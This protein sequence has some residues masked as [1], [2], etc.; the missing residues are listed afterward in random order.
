ME[1]LAQS[2][3]VLWGWRRL[4]VAAAAGALSV[5]ALP[6]FG[7]PPILFVTLPVL[8]WL[9]DGATATSGRFRAALSAAAIGWA[10]GFGYF[11][12]GLYWI[13]A[14]FLV[15]AED[16]LWALPIAISALPIGLGLF[17]GAA[18]FLARLVWRPGPWRVVP[19]ATFM[20]ASELVR[21]EILT[22]FPW[23]SFGYA[24]AVTPVSMQA[25]ALSTVYGLSFAT[26]LIFAAPAA[27][28]PRV[29]G[30]WGPPVVAAGLVAAIVGYGVLRLGSAT[31]D[32]S[33]VF[34]RIVQPA[35][36]Q[37]E[38]WKPE[39]RS[40]IF[41]TLMALSDQATSP[42]IM[43]TADLDIIIWPESALTF[44]YDREPGAQAAVAATLTSGTVLI[45]GLQRHIADSTDPRGFRAYNS[46]AAIDE[47]GQVIASYD[48]V[49]L[50][51]FGEFLPFQ[52]ALEA[53]GVEQLTRLPGGFDAG[54]SREPVRLD[55]LPAFLPLICYEIIFPGEIHTGDD[56]ADWLLNVTNDAWYGESPGPYQH[57][58]Q[59]R[60]RAVEEGLPVVRA[61]NT[62][63]SVIYD[64]YGRE[65]ASAPLNAR[66][67]VD[68][69][70]P[71][72]VA[73]PPIAATHGRLPAVLLCA[74]GFLA[75][76]VRY[77]RKDTFWL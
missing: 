57:L 18:L 4:A 47:D 70:L 8:V 7:L 58:L 36:Q 1:R 9:V 54:A 77:A 33:G 32:G 50:V 17:Y 13:G 59:A 39:N 76:L 62:G 71:A 44:L 46:I 55:G 35:I 25:A 68:G 19:F 66:G 63:I 60:L 45:T 23:N 72:P 12:A 14:A 29:C 5:I 38:K 34:V 48:K 53:W 16:F 37:E 21:G 49:N 3:I 10:F 40:S 67:V 52:D 56:R 31:P 6:P 41:N 69:E 20:T 42:E 15:E 30:S 28:A 61:A 51:P 65:I 26:F 11:L 73:N 43:G 22:G 2:V 27:L 24:I 74:I 75:S 64:A